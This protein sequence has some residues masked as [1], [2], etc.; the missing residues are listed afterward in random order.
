MQI[1]KP[2]IRS[3]VLGALIVAL[4]GGVPAFGADVI[5]NGVDLWMTVAGFAQTSFASEPIPAGFFCDSSQ[6]FTGKIV[7]K[8]APLAAYPANSLGG[9]DTAVRRLDDSA[10]ND[11]GEATTRIQLLAL[12]LAS[13]KPVETS[14]GNFDVAVNLAGEQPI[15][16]M[17]ILRTEALGGIYSAPLALNVKA[18]FTPVN[19]DKSGRREVT[20]RIELGPGSRSVWAYV[21]APQYP[22]GVKIDT[23]G[24]GQPD[25][26]LPAPSNF[27]AGVSPAVL[28]GEPARPQPAAAVSG[29]FMVTPRC[30]V[31]QCPYQSCH[32]DPN[33][34]D[35]NQSSSG[36]DHLHC[37]WVCI[38]CTVQTQPANPF[39][40]N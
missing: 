28:K 21:K 22:V 17:R 26:V 16:T 20:R 33:S 1:S 12:S 32:C 27:L 38:P 37:V 11:K 6:P 13:V 31:G 8:G 4:I 36:C 39:Q 23:N 15:T 5:H 35:P 34:T 18:V 9:I 29:D 7:F 40:D 24:D 10:F 3:A 2:L 14:C 19:G 30:P 25:T